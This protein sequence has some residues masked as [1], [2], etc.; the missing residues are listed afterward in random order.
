MDNL[1]EEDNTPPQTDPNKNYLEELVGEG[2][3][4]KD[5]ESL[6]RGKY[7]ADSYINI[8]TRQLDQM[9]D[10]YKN[11]RKDV[12]ARA[13]LEDLLKQIKPQNNETTPPVTDNKPQTQ[14]DPKDL[15]SLVSNKIQEHEATRKYQE[16]LNSVRDRLKERLGSNYREAVKEQI[17]NLGLT[18]DYFNDLARKSP[19]TLFKVLGI[20]EAPQQQPFTAPPR[21][22]STFT[23]K[24]PQ[25]RTWNYYQELK[26]T[27]PDLF[28]DPRINVQMQKD[29][30]A[31]GD[32]FMDGDFRR[33][34]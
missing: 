7:E 1:F 26:K 20:D 19:K 30:I 5:P 34:G 15:E 8:L 16:N 24:G 12:E 11:L 33:F 9:R 3:K 4:F 17:E 21:S 14:P 6:A 29:A 28:L 10:D 31:L 2:K 23:P 22:N 18:E 25:K 13:T 32:E 27:N